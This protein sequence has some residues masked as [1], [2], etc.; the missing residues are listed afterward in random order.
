MDAAWWW[1][2]AEDNN[3]NMISALHRLQSKGSRTRL[4]ALGIPVPDAFAVYQYAKAIF[5]LLKLHPAPRFG[6]EG[7]HVTIAPEE[8]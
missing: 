2:R 1:F 6:N 8:S 5:P 3:E 7:G 4:E